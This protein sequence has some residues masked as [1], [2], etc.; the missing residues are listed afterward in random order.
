[1]AVMADERKDEL[2]VQSE[3]CTGSAYIVIHP[4]DECMPTITNTAATVKYE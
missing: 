3:E 2:E 4:Y 1:M